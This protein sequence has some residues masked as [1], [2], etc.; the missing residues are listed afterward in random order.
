METF[1]KLISALAGLAWPLIFGV[2]VYK[3][4]GPIRVLVESARSRKFTIKVAGN[5]LTMAEASEQQQKLFSDLQAKISV[6]ER[7]LKSKG[8]SPVNGAAAVPAVNKRILWVDDKPRNNS[9][10]VA[11]L[12]ERGGRVDVA[13]STSDAIAQVKNHNYD[14]II[15][16]MQRPEGDDAGLDLIR[17]L[18]ESGITT[19]VHIFSSAWAAKNMRTEALQTG[20]A[21]ITSSATTL[22]SALLS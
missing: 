12:E 22:L 2:L 1:A 6:I 10:L 4:F 15:S 17:K 13:L 14:V 5:E 3:L 9:Y 19:P 21:A 16:D 7:E 8:L 11:A 18:R 20:A